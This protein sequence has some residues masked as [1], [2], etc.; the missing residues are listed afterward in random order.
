MGIV[1]ENRE[2]VPALNR[3]LSDHADL[4]IGRMGVPCR[5]RDLSVIALIV[6]G[7]TDALGS[8]TGRLGALRGVQVK[9][10]LASKR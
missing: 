6:D 10:A 7:S 3:I 2:A 4:I 9:S 8:L 1:V 5:E